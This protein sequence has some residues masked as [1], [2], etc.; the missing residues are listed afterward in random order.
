MHFF[1]Q[2]EDGIRDNKVTGV[3]TCALD[4]TGREV[5]RRMLERKKGT[6]VQASTVPPVVRKATE[7]GLKPLVR[8]P[9]KDGKSTTGSVPVVAAPQPDSGAVK[10]PAVV[11]PSPFARSASASVPTIPK[12]VPTTPFAAIGPS[13]PAEGT[14]PGRKVQATPLGT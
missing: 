2:A 8:I 14:A 10:K 5:H 13:R 7:P 11:A 3:Q 1:L 12:P 6:T 4:S 9:D